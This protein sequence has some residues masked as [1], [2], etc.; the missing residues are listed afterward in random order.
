MEIEKYDHCIVGAGPSGLTLAYKLLQKKFEC[1]SEY[2]PNGFSANFLSITGLLIGLLAAILISLEF[3][4]LGMVMIISNRF[5]DGLDGA[6]ARRKGETSFGGYIDILFDFIFYSSVVFG[7]AIA[8]LEK[9]SLA[10]IFLLFSFVG[11][12]TSFLAFALFATSVHCS[13][14]LCPHPLWSDICSG[15]Y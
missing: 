15:V 14:E 10:A 4:F 11:T 7:F 6:V 9:N 13:Q 8:N 2:L 1:I 5:F 12:G 3:Y